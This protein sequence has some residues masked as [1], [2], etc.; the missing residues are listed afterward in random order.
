M[1]LSSTVLITGSSGYIGA[2]FVKY[3]S[4]EGLRV[5]GVDQVAPFSTLKKYLSAYLVANIADQEAVFEFCQTQKVKTVLHCA[6]SCLVGESVQF[7]E[8]Y[9]ENNVVRAQKFLETITSLGVKIF[10][11]SSTAAIYGEPVHTPMV[12]SHPKNPINPYGKT[13][14]Q[15]E[16]VLLEKEKEGEIIVGILRYFN[17]AGADPEA[18]IGE[19][20]DPETHLIPNA[21]Y[22]ALGMKKSFELYGSD[23]PT[24]D[25]TC[26]R[27]FI[28]VWDLAE[29]H[30]RLLN[31][32]IKESKG[33]IYN[34]GTGTGF[35]VKEVLDEVDHQTKSL[36]KREIKAR[37]IGDPTILVADPTL[38]R[39]D[40][41]WIPQY[42]S[43]S[44]IVSTAL[45]WHMKETH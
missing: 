16:N 33:G 37:R 39:K 11:F 14:L 41:H 25:G 32:M 43:L 20:H 31:K 2:H 35:T 5:V 26:V 17:A 34:L 3:F 42:S 45:K 44:I 10:I 9:H 40:L 1:A 12:E 23:Y 29:A 7:P 30:L 8:R 6:A 18:E 24:Q 21:I 28:H 19:V 38:A 22:A 36:L 13:K 4:K 15:F 27:D